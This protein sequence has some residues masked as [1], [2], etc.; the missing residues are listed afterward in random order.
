MSP[1]AKV[2][3]SFVDA[4]PAVDRLGGPGA[5]RSAASD[6]TSRALDRSA[7]SARRRAR[8]DPRPS[9]PGHAEAIRLGRPEVSP[10]KRGIHAHRNPRGLRRDARPRQG[11]RVRLPGHQRHLVPDPRRRPPGLRR[12][13]LRRHH[14]GLDRRRRVR[15]RPDRQGHGH[16]RRRARRVRARGRQELPDQRSRCTPTTAPRTSSTASSVRCS[17]SRPSASKRGQHPLFQ[18]HMWDGS[19]VPLEEN[20]EIAEELLD[21]H[22]GRQHHPRDR[23]RRR[24]RR[25]G[26]RRRR[27][28]RQALHH[29]RGRHRAP[30]R[31]SASARRA[32]T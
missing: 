20:L 6:W 2:P 10:Q 8:A 29:R 15:L 16:R 25:G 5:T 24:R 1:S 19:A 3:A 7:L 12:G 18:S 13:R 14:P 23:D 17:P 22:Q 32:A 21:A 27:D 11:G 4:S 31:R 30:S 9:S 26:R 28:Q